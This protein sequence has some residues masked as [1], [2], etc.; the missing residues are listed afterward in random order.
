MRKALPF[1]VFVV[2]FAL[3]YVGTCY[4]IP[5]LRIKLAAEPM[6]Y[7]IESLQHGVAFKATISSAIGL[8]AALFTRFFLRRTNDEEKHS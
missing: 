2:V 4:L 7:F 6:V 1:V 5:G 8:A 3:V